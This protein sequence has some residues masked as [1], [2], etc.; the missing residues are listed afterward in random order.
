MSIRAEGLSKKFKINNSKYHNHTTLRDLLGSKILGVFK[1]TPN[2][3]IEKEVEIWALKDLNF[4]IEQGDKVAL[5]GKNGAGKSTLL[6]ILSRILS[7]TSG[8]VT[9]DGKISSLIEVG[10]GFHHELNAKENIY[11]SGIILGMSKSEIKSKIDEILNFAE[12]EQYVNTP[13][14]R[15]SSGMQIRLAF[16]VA[17]HLISDILI[18]DEVLAVGDSRFQLKCIEK[19]ND[20]TKSGKTLLFVSH[21]IGNINKICNKGICLHNGQIVAQGNIDEVNTFYNSI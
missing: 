17:A 1:D 3:L 8:Q 2:D 16:S 5:I 18:L 21:D 19:I 11:L 7:P 6:K 14:K 12:I 9:I 20:I 15:Y 4:E 13:V 10:T